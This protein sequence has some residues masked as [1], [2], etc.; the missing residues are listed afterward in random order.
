MLMTALSSERLEVGTCM[1]CVCSH[2]RN[3]MS[4][5]QPHYDAEVVQ[6]SS[7]CIKFEN[8]F[9]SQIT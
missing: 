8:D 2:I 3:Y 5:G 9:N 7:L 1:H 4:I 6:R